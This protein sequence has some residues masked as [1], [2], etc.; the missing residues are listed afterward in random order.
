MNFQFIKIIVCIAT[1]NRPFFLQKALIS[2]L[3]QNHPADKILIISDS[4]DKNFK[5]EKEICD[6]LNCKNLILL[7]NN[8]LEFTHN[9]AGSLNYGIFEYL[10]MNHN[11]VEE[12]DHTY[13]AFLDDDDWWS[14]EYLYNCWTKIRKNINIDFVITGLNFIS[15]D[16]KIK[17][18]IPQTLTVKNFLI[19]NPHLQG[20]NTF[21]K[22]STLLK[23][24]CFDE[25]F[26]S[27]VDRDFFVRLMFLN[28]EYSVINKHL[29]YINASNNYSRITN[30][31]NNKIDAMKKFLYKY[32]NL[33]TKEIKNNFFKNAYKLFLI[34]KKDVE[35]YE[36]SISSEN[37]K[38][39]PKPDANFICNITFGIIITDCDLG[40]RI[41]KEIINLELKKYKLIIVRNFLEDPDKIIKILKE[42][43][44][45]FKFIDFN[46]IEN[47]RDKKIFINTKYN[48]SKVKDISISRTILNYFLKN[49]SLDGPIW[50]I[51]EDMEFYQYEN[52]GKALIKSKVD[53]YEII[54]NYKDYDVVIGGYSQDS[55]LPFLST[56]RTGILDFFYFKKLKWKNNESL[57]LMKEDYYYDLSDS[58]RTHLET[59]Y[60]Y[61]DKKEDSINY[62]FNGKNHSRQLFNFSHSI[63]EPKS[64]GGNTLIFNK[65]VLDYPNWSIIIDDLVARRSDYFWTLYLKET[66]KFKIIS[67]PFSLFHNRK[68][69]KFKIEYEEKKLLQDLVGSSFTKSI[70]KNLEYFLDLE[71]LNTK[72][73]VNNFQYEFAKRLGKYIMSY[74]R[75][76]G[77]LS[78]LNDKKYIKIFTIKRLKNFILRASEYNKKWIIRHSFSTFKRDLKMNKNYLNELENIQNNLEN[79]LNTKLL[80]LGLGSE[81]MVFHDYRFVYKYFYNSFDNESELLSYLN[82][83]KN[84]KNFYEV[85]LFYINDNPVIKY[86]YEKAE[87]LKISVKDL[88]EILIFLI[89]N[90]I[91][92]KNFKPDN[93]IKTSNSLKII[94][95]GKSFEFN[96]D[97]N[98]IELMIR[99][100]AELFHYNHLSDDDFKKIIYRWYENKSIRNIIDFNYLNLF[101]LVNQRSKEEIHDV[102]TINFVKKYEFKSILDYGA[103][104]CR[105]ANQLMKETGKDVFVF[106]VD[107]KTLNK[108][109]E[110]KNKIITNINLNKNKFD[111]VICNLV[112]C[113]VTDDWVNRILNNIK[114]KSNSNTHIILSI[115][116]PFF[117]YVKNTEIASK[118]LGK[119]FN[120]FNNKKIFKVVHSTQQERIDFHRPIQY[121]LNLFK[122]YNLFIHEA[123]ETD[124][125]NE[126]NLNSISDFLTL[127][128]SYR[129]KE[130]I[131][132]EEKQIVIIIRN[133]KFVKN[134]DMK[135]F[136]NYLIEQKDQNFEIHFVNSFK[137]SVSEY[138]KF[139]FEND[140]YFMKI[141][142]FIQNMNLVDYINKKIKNSK[143]LLFLNYDQILVNNSSTELMNNFIKNNNDWILFNYLDG[144][145]PWKENNIIHGINSP[146][147][148]KASKLKKYLNQNFI[149]KLV[150]QNN[151][152]TSDLITFLEIRHEKY[153]IQN[154]Q[155]FLFNKS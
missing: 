151:I 60:L 152:K 63:S 109:M 70:N 61:K 132:K 78:C 142:K 131:K 86:K 93:F 113:C 8:K 22:L 92:Y 65:D 46:D 80:F 134:E 49:L 110:D 53:V 5:K 7:K 128:L 59:P 149:K 1:K 3:N 108:N 122:K 15:D 47:I 58:L 37:K 38:K 102:I 107:L 125:V 147:L 43:N 9:Y 79:N 14:K 76:H 85:E 90:K 31:K 51:D 119:N 114:E 72:E 87:K 97:E 35:E 12:F 68:K 39:F 20:S 27:M 26:N 81:G 29:V 143:Y 111:I 115:C 19:K 69:T 55:P 116:N 88:K 127:D 121:Y 44:I 98:N 96:I 148:V 84:S 25:N 150:N 129:E 18:T 136:F 4:D 64:R 91:F 41:I 45:D 139:L 120:Y 154:E 17:L 137:N 30:N 124:G 75:I 57:N 104:K 16:K 105:I 23:A 155:L 67:A 118:N 21:V 82:I 112:L 77:L 28:P 126:D 40:F 52:N 89:N 56:L 103:G 153:F 13:F 144:L 106:D 100:S 117:S 11:K 83:I 123:K 24:G 140:N 66:K 130:K 138:V 99:R 36:L 95:Y 62:L 133:N 145:K 6:S 73:F 54:Q 34:E 10:N 48:I 74:Y 42:N 33:M 2:V 146:F 94:D 141:G 101:K 32:E 71:N 135:K 50:I